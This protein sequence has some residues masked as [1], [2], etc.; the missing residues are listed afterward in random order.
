M[1]L[2]VLWCGSQSPSTGGKLATSAL[3]PDAL[4]RKQVVLSSLSPLEHTLRAG[5]ML[6]GVLLDKGLVPQQV[7]EIVEVGRGTF[8]LR[9]ARPGDRLSLYRDESGQVMLFEMRR[10]G[11]GDTLVVRRTPMGLIASRREPAY[12]VRLALAEGSITSS[13]YAD[14][15]R[16]GLDGRLVMDLAEIFAWDIDFL[17]DLQPGD[18]FR[19]IYEQKV[20]ETGPAQ[21]GRILAAEM[22]N[23][24]QIHTAY[25]FQDD[26]G[27]AG[28]YDAGG[29]ALQK[30]FLKSP[31][32]YSRISSGFSHA[33][34]HPV[35]KIRRPH[36]GVDYAAPAGTPVE[37]VA[38]GR[39][40][41]CGW[42][43]G[44]GRY[45][46]IRHRKGLTT[47]YGHLSAFGRGLRRGELV[48][49]GQV[50][51]YVGATGMATGP[52]LDFRIA[53]NGVWVDP[54]K[55][56]SREAKPIPAAMRARFATFV[57]QV[58]ARFP[59]FET[60]ASQ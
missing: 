54:L 44:F 55:K 8:D 56:Q 41:Y 26:E 60:T 10:A 49:Q 34:L 57:S 23:N 7:N 45:V 35:L 33:R 2:L 19:V 40:T 31:L 28:Y 52:H 42:K 38:D 47:C 59:S 6:Y 58:R 39:V 9:R 27:H 1:L 53:E 20:A 16:E 5:E 43:G 12:S 30:E 46:E 36:L 50:I 24:G 13:L 51:G 48:R 37:A 4:E 17:S 21:T 18:T 29:R 32:R 25:Y 22:V 14:A 11:S 3:Y 15:R